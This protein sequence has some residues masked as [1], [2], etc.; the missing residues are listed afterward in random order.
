MA[1][2]TVLL[3][4]SLMSTR[5]PQA[6]H[7]I[8][9]LP[10][11][12]PL[13]LNSSS[14]NYTHQRRAVRP[15]NDIRCVFKCSVQMVF[16]VSTLF[17][18]CDHDKIFIQECL[19]HAECVPHSFCLMGECL[20]RVPS[21]CSALTQEQAFI[22]ASPSAIHF[23]GHLESDLRRNKS[24]SLR[25]IGLCPAMIYKIAFDAEALHCDSC[26][27]Q[28]LPRTL[29]PGEE[30]QL[31][32]QPHTSTF[33]FQTELLVSSNDAEHPTL[34]VPIYIAP[35][36]PFHIQP[37]P[38]TFGRVEVGES[39]EKRITLLNFSSS[40]VEIDSLTL[41]H[42]AFS[43]PTPPKTR[44]LLG[45]QNKTPGKLDLI[46]M[47]HPIDLARHEGHLKVSFQNGAHIIT[48]LHGSSLSPPK[49]TVT[50]RNLSFGDIEL[51]HTQAK[52]LVITNEGGSTLEF[53]P[54][55]LSHRDDIF[56]LI[57]GP[58]RITPGDFS[59]LSVFA[60][61]LE[62]GGF[63]G[64]L[65]LES[66]DP[67]RPVLP[68]EL[69]GSASRPAP[70]L[71]RI[72]MRFQNG[73]SSVFGLDLREVDLSIENFEGQVCGQRSS[74]PCD[75]GDNHQPKWFGLGT[76]NEPERIVLLDSPDD[77]SYNVLLYYREDCSSAP[78]RYIAELLGVSF[79]TLLS[80]LTGGLSLPSE[81][82]ISLID[83]LCIS[84]RSTSALVNVYIDNILV[85]EVSKP[86]YSRGELSTALRLVRENKSF[87]VEF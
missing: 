54:Q 86:L 80:E 64:V 55:F 65:N 85:A 27:N 75:W 42:H 78:T 52:D 51:G 41:D 68:I 24:I 84:R 10:Q 4:P 39:V 71:V 3:M 87:R 66:N 17:V 73:D 7:I 79:E 47:Y 70:G 35:S 53:L 49:L 25:N 57:P 34:R 50:T 28:N 61:P 67:G 19:S 1:L 72:D 33:A 31:N 26:R 15:F 16:A 58:L 82:L 9:V 59:I 21:D 69:S 13:E 29:L 32:L 14:C 6:S 45:A 36:A 12:Q 62:A 23:G 60:S 30:L 63:R 48:P 56:G 76:R 81:E 37:N 77:T 38:V 18:G 46:V 11:Q 44:G 43:L 8:T 40:S 20:P 74:Q 83:N 22:Q 5:S 2:F